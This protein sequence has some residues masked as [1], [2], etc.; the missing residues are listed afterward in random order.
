M[1]RRPVV[2]TAF[3]I[4]ALFTMGTFCLGFEIAIDVSPQT[5]NIQSEGVVVT[6]HTNIAYGVVDVYSVFLNGVHIQ[7]W[8]AD[9][10]G[11]FVAKFSME[12]VKTLDGLV[13]GGYNELQLV[14]MT[15][16][17]ESFSGTAEIMVIDVAPEGKGKER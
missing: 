11:N 6:A 16:D 5:L 9:N 12:E 4:L 8:K 10:R 7:S 1:R 2:F 15:L 3:A 14:G 17:H 13:I